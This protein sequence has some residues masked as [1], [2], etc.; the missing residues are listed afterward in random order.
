MSGRSYGPNLLSILD[1]VVSWNP[2]TVRARR[3]DHQPGHPD[4]Q[5]AL[6]PT[7]SSPSQTAA[8]AYQ[9]ILVEPRWKFDREALS[10]SKGP[11]ARRGILA[12]RYLWREIL[13]TQAN[14]LDI[15]ASCKARP[16][17]FPMF[18]RLEISLLCK[19]SC[20]LEQGRALLSG[21]RIEATRNFDCLVQH[22]H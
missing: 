7:R 12:A 19:G 6:G 3:T 15:S 11:T 16:L 17:R 1:I 20:S 5:A 10:V 13:R 22:D 2:T 18:V 4:Y 8:L 14:R 21:H 9:Q